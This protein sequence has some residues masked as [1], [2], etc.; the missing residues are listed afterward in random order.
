MNGTDR[1]TAAACPRP[2]AHDSLYTPVRVTAPVLDE[3]SGPRPPGGPG[4]VAADGRVLASVRLHGHPLGLA[5]ATGAAGEYATLHRALV[6]AASGGDNDRT[7]DPSHDSSRDP[8]HDR[9]HEHTARAH[10]VAPRAPDHSGR[11]ATR[12]RPSQGADRLSAPSW[13][14]IPGTA[15]SG[16]LRPGCLSAHRT[17]ATAGRVGRACRARCP[18]TSDVGEAG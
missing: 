13:A 12:R 16:R 10:L 18:G 6:D 7:H 1:R 17:R 2:A 9:S 8:S 3:A 4:T 15:R 14:D 5:T 11:A